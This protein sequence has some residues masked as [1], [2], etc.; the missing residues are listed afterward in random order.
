MP[1]C[2]LTQQNNEGKKKALLLLEYSHPCQDQVVVV[3]WVAR[4]AEFHREV[5]RQENFAQIC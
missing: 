4:E 5:H 1:Q 3:G 2:T